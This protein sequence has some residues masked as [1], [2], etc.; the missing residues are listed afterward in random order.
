MIVRFSKLLTLYNTFKIH[1]FLLISKNELLSENIKI[2]G[3]HIGFQIKTTLFY[4]KFFNFV[5]RKNLI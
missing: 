1:Y 3:F 2:G 5:F 4:T